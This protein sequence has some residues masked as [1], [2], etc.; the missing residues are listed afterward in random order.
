MS[1]PSRET[2]ASM[3]ALATALDKQIAAVERRHAEAGYPEHVTVYDL[4]D[5]TG[6]PVLAELLVAKAKVEL[7]LASL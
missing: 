7:W 2:L 4:V 3:T 6:R 1:T 5:Q